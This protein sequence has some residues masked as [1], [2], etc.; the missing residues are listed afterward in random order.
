MK[1][2][3]MN[4]N[5]DIILKGLRFIFRNFYLSEIKHLVFFNKVKV[6]SSSLDSIPDN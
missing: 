1:L 6:I 3:P 2:S 4:Q 5:L